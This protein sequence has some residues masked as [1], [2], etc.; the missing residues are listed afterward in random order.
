MTFKEKNPDMKSNNK[1]TTILST[2]KCNA[3][4]TLIIY[5]V[6]NIICASYVLL[7]KNFY[8]WS[9][10]ESWN[11]AIK[12]AQ[13][14]FYP[15]L[16]GE[17]YKSI[18][19]LEVNYL[20]ALPSALFVLIFGQSRLVY[21]LSLANFYAAPI[22]ILIYFMSKKIGK[23]PLVTLAMLFLTLP[24]IMYMVF[25]GFAEIGGVLIGLSCMYIYLCNNSNSSLKYIIIGV[26]LTF[27]IIWSH[28]FI[29]FTAAFVASMIIESII[30]KKSPQKAIITLSVIILILSL[31]FR[32]Y[33]LT[34][35]MTLYG[36]TS[37]SLNVLANIKYLLRY[38]GLILLIALIIQSFKSFKNGFKD[39]IIFLWSNIIVCFIALITTRTHGQLHILPYLPAV[40]VLCII[41]IKHI[42]NMRDLVIASIL[43]L[44]QII[45]VSIP[46]MQPTSVNDIKTYSLLPTFTIAAKSRSDYKDILKLKRKLDAIVWNGEYL[47]VLAYSDKLNPDLLNNSEISANHFSSRRDYIAFT[48]PYFDSE[49]P[50]ISPLCNANYMLVATPLQSISDNQKILS[51]AA[52]SFENNSDIAKAYEL[53]ENFTQNIDNIE[54]KLYKRVRTPSEY[55]KQKF[56]N[57]LAN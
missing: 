24:P 35:I 10:A 57:K 52:E 16:W 8:Y 2:T 20:S 27:A 42:Y 56:L 4:V 50:D 43:S 31:F 26:L 28:A 44:S 29:F 47:G 54:V 15:N 37:Q 38:I 46:R 7:S 1:S 19:S 55:E 30:V 39:N 41:S 53:V 17:I 9:T 11:I 14:A 34:R 40:I 49:I 51:S 12:I 6:I 23:A 3:K 45:S 18:L 25:M 21:I 5:A 13:G 22:F 33:I 48:I 36:G 32:E